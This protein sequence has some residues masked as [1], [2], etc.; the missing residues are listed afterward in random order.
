MTKKAMTEEEFRQFCYQ[1]NVDPV[2][3][4]K[5]AAIKGVEIVYVTDHELTRHKFDEWAEEMRAR[6]AAA[7]PQPKPKWRL[8]WIKE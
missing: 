6:E 5:T 4:L 1:Y 7:R 2:T 3:G 8:R